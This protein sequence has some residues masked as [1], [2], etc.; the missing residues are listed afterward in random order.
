LGKTLL[1]GIR[2]YVA[3]NHIEIQGLPADPDAE[4][5]PEQVLDVFRD[6]LA[7]FF[8]LLAPVSQG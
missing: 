7:T 5:A 8:P 1:D 3:Q 4:I 2:A 6:F